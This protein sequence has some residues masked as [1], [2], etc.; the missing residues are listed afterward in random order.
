MTSQKYLDPPNVDEIIEKVKT[1]PT[2]GDIKLLAEEIFPDWY[3]STAKEYSKDYPNLTEN[4]KVVCKAIKITQAQILFVNDVSF[5][6][7]HSIIRM[8]SECFTRA[9]FSV[10]KKNDY[11]ECSKCNAVIPSL[12]LWS[13]FKE[14]GFQVPIIWSSNCVSCL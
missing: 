10:R 9:G 5:D 4:W 7:E 2:I 1:L 12:E 3:V 14:K 11:T 8:F 6:N 13:I